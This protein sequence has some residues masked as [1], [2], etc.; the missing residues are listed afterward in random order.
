MSDG[1]NEDTAPEVCDA[2]DSTPP[3]HGPVDVFEEKHRGGYNQMVAD[4]LDDTL[5]EKQRKTKKDAAAKKLK[6]AISKRMEDDGDADAK[7]ANDKLRERNNDL[8]SLSRADA[9]GKRNAGDQDE[10]DKY[11]IESKQNNARYASYKVVRLAG[12]PKAH[13]AYDIKLKQTNDW[14]EAKRQERDSNRDMVEV[15]DEKYMGTK[16]FVK[17]DVWW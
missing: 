10:I 16:Q 6:R 3:M 5:S 17:Q 8:Q 1:M 4:S 11:N 2:L 12:D 9:T 13:A 14:K 15:E 7:A